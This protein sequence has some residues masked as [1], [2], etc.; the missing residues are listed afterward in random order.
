M[1]LPNIWDAMGARLM[2]KI[3]FPSVA[4][5]SVATAITNGYQD[6][7][8][9]P[10]SLLLKIVGEICSAIELPVTVDI[11]RGFAHS[12]PQLKENIRLLIEQGAVGINLEDSKPNHRELYSLSEQCMKIEAVRETGVA[13]GVPLV[14]NART[15][16]FMIGMEDKA[17][18]E[19]ITRGRAYKAAGAD[20]VYPVTIG[21]YEEITRFVQALEMPVN[22]LLMKSIADLN[23]LKEIGVSRVSLGPNLLSHVITVMKEVA[24]GLIQNDSTRF[25]SK[26]LISREFRDSLAFL[27]DGK[28]E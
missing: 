20:C 2:E 24:E 1:I 28:S 4:T 6:G 3:G 19:G 27:T 18:P 16:V 23:R 9:I 10:Y 26:E 5:A 14:I 12:I 15:D 7:E 17:V 25:F 11:E 22:V 21:S 8:H 13:C